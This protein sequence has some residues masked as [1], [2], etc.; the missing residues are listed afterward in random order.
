MK[1]II[2]FLSILILFF[3]TSS[4]VYAS[5]NTASSYVLMDMDSN[6]V[7]LSKNKDKR[8]LIA[9]ITKIMT[10]IIAIESNKL[11]DIVKI[12]NSILKSYG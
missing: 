10:A 11:D 9:S 4:K 3:S 7:L 12:D 2:V 1:K 8:M 5:V 6:R